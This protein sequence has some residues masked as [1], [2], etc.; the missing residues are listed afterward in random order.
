MMEAYTG[1]A[2]VYDI[3]MDNVPYEEWADYIEDILKEYGIED[4]LVLD[5]GCGTGSMTQELAGRGYDMIGVDYSGEMLEIAMEKKEKS[6][7]DI[8]YLLQ[9][10]RE[11]ELYG[12]VRAVVSACDSVNYITEEE[13][14]VQ[15]F[16][17][18]N[19]YLD[20]KGI[21]LFD[22]NTEYKYREVL[23]ESTIAEDREECSFIWDNYYD[24]EDQ[25]NEY[26][27]TLF[28]REKEGLYR[29]YQEQHFQKAYTL[30][31]MKR[32]IEESGLVFETA[33]DAYTRNAPG[34]DS[35]RICVIAR[36]HGK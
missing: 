3:F 4:G 36:E 11:F 1:F 6:G 32:L 7:A 17:L 13:E 20:P 14:L 24:E 30:D 34:E 22:F 18:V 28:I 9:D 2:E 15:V 19:N 21:F 10:M 35:E 29:K 27:L 26:E 12:T 31:T 8:L 16:R 25:I 33:Y 23:G 5:L